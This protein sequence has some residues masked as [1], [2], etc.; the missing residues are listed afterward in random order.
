MLE[1]INV[2]KG[3]KFI[4]GNSTILNS[5]SLLVNEGEILAIMGASGAGKST[6]L[7]II[8]MFDRNYQGNYFF[9]NTDTTKLSNQAFDNL[10]HEKIGFI[11]QD[12]KLIHTLNVF[13]NVMVPMMYKKMA[14]SETKKLVMNSLQRVGML[15]Y[16]KQFP[17]QLSGGQKQRVAIARALVTEP[18]LLIADEPT[19]A[20]D[21][22]TSN[23]IM[24]IIKTSSKDAKT[25]V[26]IV[27][28]DP[29]VSEQADRIV[30]LQDGELQD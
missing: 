24:E 8:G 3:F 9:K 2:T 22:K 18:E 30:Y 19:G 16:S 13:D 20:L 6:L 15:Q 26:V 29:R 23:L 12:F 21:T 17:K 14:H 27:T 28:H 4:S 25:T 1:L 10:R 7:N 11:F 5:I